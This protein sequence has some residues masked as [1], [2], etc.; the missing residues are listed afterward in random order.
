MKIWSD[1]L[2]TQDIRIAQRTVTGVRIERMTGISRPRVRRHGW[3]VLLGRPSSNRHF[4]TGKHGAGDFGAAT[5]DD[6]GRFLAVLFERDPG[7]RAAYYEGR[8]RFHVAT[9][10]KF[11]SISGW[12]ENGRVTSDDDGQPVT[13]MA[14][15]GACGRSWNDALITSMTPVPAGRCPYE[16]EHAED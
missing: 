6:Y 16:S 15:C 10:G 7:M 3:N 4:N 8:D 14:T 9:K 1:V 12:G 2:T 13:V 5:W 11:A